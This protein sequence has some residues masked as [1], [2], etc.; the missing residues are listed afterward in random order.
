MAP[1]SPNPTQQPLARKPTL[2]S[3]NQGSTGRSEPMHFRCGRRRRGYCLGADSA[4][5]KA[6]SQSMVD[7][8]DHSDKAGAALQERRQS[9]GF[10]CHMAILGAPAPQSALGCGRVPHTHTNATQ[11]ASSA[12]ALPN[13]NAA[14]P[15]APK[16]D[17]LLGR[18]GAHGTFHPSEA[19]GHEPPTPLSSTCPGGAATVHTLR[20]SHE[21]GSPTQQGHLLV[22]GECRRPP[23]AE[24]N[25]R[26]FIHR[27]N[28]SRRAAALI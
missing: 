16:D 23:T 24:R 21:C 27:R 15:T 1:A 6:P 3:R 5:D 9:D 17:D 4:L 18:V 19:V 11:R 7:A 25:R 10:G 20:A 2:P 14:A 28:D 13:P 22:A 26:E 8:R 12:M